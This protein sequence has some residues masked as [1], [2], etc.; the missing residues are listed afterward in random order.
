MIK[1]LL[2][3]KFVQQLCGVL[4]LGELGF[5]DLA[6]ASPSVASVVGC[7]PHLICVVLSYSQV[8]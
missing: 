8:F 2:L 7:T 1:I 4:V 3:W 6:S 5:L